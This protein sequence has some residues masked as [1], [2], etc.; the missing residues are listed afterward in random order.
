[1]HWYVKLIHCLCSVTCHAISKGWSHVG[2]A[3][4]F[5]LLQINGFSP[6]CQWAPKEQC[7]I[8]S[9][10]RQWLIKAVQHDS[11]INISDSSVK[12][13]FVI[14]FK[15][16]EVLSYYGGHKFVKIHRGRCKCRTLLLYLLE[17]LLKPSYP[18]RA[19]SNLEKK[20]FQSADVV[21]TKWLIV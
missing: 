9:T 15:Q 16:S 21:D 18:I 4:K 12:V 8:S 13:V 3:Q 10:E 5:Y 19:S 6:H 17:W 20:Y 14:N 2:A 7:E 1:M 11:N